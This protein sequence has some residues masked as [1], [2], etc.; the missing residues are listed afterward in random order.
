[1]AQADGS[2]PPGDTREW[3]GVTRVAFRFCFL[4]L[5]LYVLTTQM[6]GSLIALPI[7]QLERLALLSPLVSWTAKHVFGIASPLVVFSGSGDKTYDWV[8]VFCLLVIASAGT[9]LWPLLGRRRPEETALHRRF[10]VFLRLALGA[11]LVQ[12]GLAKVI[13]LQMPEPG[14]LRLIERFGD[15][16]PMGVLWASVGASQPYEIFTGCVELI[17]GALLFAPQTALLGGL[18]TLAATTQVFVLNMTYDVPVKQFSFHLVLLSLFVIAPDARRLVDVILLNRPAVPS[19]LR[20]SGRR[21][22]RWSIPQLAF[23][24]YVVVAT[25]ISNVSMWRTYGGGAAKPPLY[26]VWTVDEMTRDGVLLPPLLSDQDRWRRVVVQWPGSITF[27][28]MDDAL[29]TYAASVDPVRRSLALSRRDDKDWKASFVFEQPSPKELVLDGTLD[30]HR[31]HVRTML[32][33]RSSFQ[34]VNRGFSW[35]QEYPFNR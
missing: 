23:G 20:A 19:T 26:G 21:T 35:V 30:G 25:G 4:Y 18:V 15:F 5:G 16:S 33:D 27:Q 31:L 28:R 7:P 11:T 6:L 34:L 10:H 22:R 24:A 32:V 13:P 2:T 8:Q 12:Y 29:T 1:M 17:G 14:P 3:S 9:A